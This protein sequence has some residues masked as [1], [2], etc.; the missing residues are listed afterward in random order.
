[1]SLRRS[2]AVRWIA[3]TLLLPFATVSFAQDGARGDCANTTV[4]TAL[5]EAQAALGGAETMPAIHQMALN[6]FSIAAACDYVP[7]EGQLAQHVALLLKYLS[8]Q[9]ILATR[10][11]GVDVDEILEQLGG[12]RGDPL[13]GLTLYNG[14]ESTF[15]GS[16]LT[17]STCHNGL[18]APT[19]EGSYTRVLKQRLPSLSGYTVERYLVESLILPEDYIAPGYSNA[20]MPSNLGDQLDLQDLADLIAYI[21]SQDQEIAE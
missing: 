15:S 4:E 10:R 19:T 6:L 17:C 11:I 12:I 16:S 13:R 8:V 3:V 18:I 5:I 9:E 7:D 2:I 21:E 20:L 14:G 1:M